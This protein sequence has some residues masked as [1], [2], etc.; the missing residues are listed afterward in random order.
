MY[1]HGA[2][3]EKNMQ[4]AAV[5]CQK[6]AE[7]GDATAQYNPGVAYVNG[8]GIETDLNQAAK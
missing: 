2:G 4:Q 5:W 8:D 6:A 3:V 1:K 7:Q